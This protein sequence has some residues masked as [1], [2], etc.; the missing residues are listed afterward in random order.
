MLDAPAS[1]AACVL[2]ALCIH[3]LQHAAAVLLATVTNKALVAAFSLSEAMPE[4][5]QVLLAIASGAWLLD[6]SWVQASLQA[7]A[8]LPEAP[9][10]AQVGSCT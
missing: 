1:Y 3:K 2:P 10:A 6:P 9:F 4:G 5:L 7:G 8:W